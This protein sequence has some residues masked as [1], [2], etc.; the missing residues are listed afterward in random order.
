MKSTRILA[1]LLV[2]ALVAGIFVGCGPKETPAE[3]QA[4]GTTEQAEGDKEEEK[5]DEPQVLRLIDSSDIPSLDPSVATDA[6]SFKV[7]ANIQEGLY[8]LTKN[9][10]VEPGVAE[11]YTMAEDGL[12]YTFKLRENAIWTNGETVTAHDFVYSWRRLADPNTVSQYNFMLETAG[13]VNAAEVIKGELP[14]EELGV[15][16]LDDYT[17]EVKLAVPVP[18]FISV[19]TFPSFLPLN[20]EFVASHGDAFGTSIETTLFNGPFVLSTWETEYEYVMTKNDQY[21]E[22]DRVKLDTI[23]SRIVKDSNTSINLYEAGDVDRAGLVGEQIEQYEEHPH[24]VSIPGV[25]VFYLKMNQANEVFSNINARK[26]FAM[27]IEKTFIADEILANGSMGAD[28]LVPKTLASGP[29]GKDF[30]DGAGLYNSY[31]K[32]EAAKYWAIAKEELGVDTVEIEFLTFDSESSRRISEYIQGQLQANL[33]G[34]TVVIAQQPFKNKLALEKAGDFDF[35]F[36]G[37]GPDYADPMTFLDM[38]TT[39]SGH[40]ELSYSNEEYDTIIQRAKS[41]DLTTDLATRWTELQRAEKILLGDDVALIPI[42]QKG[43]KGLEKPYIKN[44]YRHN[45]G[46]DYTYKDTY[47]DK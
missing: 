40:N 12:T 11:S 16:A 47:L 8:S 36:S 21:W 25:T 27:A 6:V 30:R 5:N 23:Q 41:G 4:K 15:T 18:Y 45:F 43:A 3:E 33:E 9:D 32:E 39:D 46:P 10:A 2:V 26:A 14:V 37:W 7:L 28:Y 31:S 1:L 19:I 17:L 20:E 35:S 22:A 24:L 44:L 42:F 34:L 13:I 29:D 38:W